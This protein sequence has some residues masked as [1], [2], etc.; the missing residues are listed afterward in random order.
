MASLGDILHALLGWLADLVQWI[1]G[2]IPRYLWV[3]SNQVGAMA[4]GGRPYRALGPGIHWYV[5]N[6]D[7]YH[8]VVSSRQ[9]LEVQAVTLQTPEGDAV[10]VGAV[11]TFHVADPIK[12][13]IE[14]WDADAGVAEFAQGALTQVVTTE[15]WEKLMAPREGGT[16]LGKRLEQRLGK[17]LE[18]FGIE[19]EWVRPTHQAKLRGAFHVF[20]IAGAR[21]TAAAPRDGA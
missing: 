15:P 7:D 6:W 14:N 10:H 12:H 18:R 3:R 4:R 21:D 19:V 13:L 17:D 2:W 16:W 5:P 11:V 1:L 9:T 20:G 8:T